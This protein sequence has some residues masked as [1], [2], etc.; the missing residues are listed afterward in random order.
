MPV[1]ALSYP[2][3][4]AL[5]F[6]PTPPAGGVGM[7]EE[8]P[9]LVACTRRALLPPSPAGAVA[10]ENERDRGGEGEREKER[11]RI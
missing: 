11:E 8:D 9:P 4:P 6:C 10:K 7:E 1:A 5:T 2:I 3:S